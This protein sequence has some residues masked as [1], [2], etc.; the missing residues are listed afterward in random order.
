MNQASRKNLSKC[1]PVVGAVNNP[2]EENGGLRNLNITKL[3]K[4]ELEP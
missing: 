2:K 1:R 4:K 3:K